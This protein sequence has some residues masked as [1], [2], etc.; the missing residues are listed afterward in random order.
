MGLLELFQFEVVPIIGERLVLHELLSPVGVHVGPLQFEE[1]ELLVNLVVLLANL[2]QQGAALG[3]VRVGRPVEIGVRERTADAVRERL[4]RGER[5]G[6]RVGRQRT[7]AATVCIG[8]VGGLFGSRV[9]VVFKRRTVGVEIGQVPAD[10]FGASARYFHGYRGQ[11][12][13]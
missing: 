6:Q 8:K 4:V 12:G 11:G 9:E 13:R 7:D 1:D 3:V 2:L 5:L 10:G